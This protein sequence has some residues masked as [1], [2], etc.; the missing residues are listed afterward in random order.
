MTKQ[1]R[2]EDYGVMIGKLQKGIRNKITDVPGVKVGH[3]TLDEGDIKTGVTAIM[4]IPQNIF[5]QKCI[6]AAHVINGY[7]KTI[8][9]VQVEEL[10][11]LES[12]IL[13]TNTLCASRVADALISYTLDRCKKEEVS[14]LSFNPVVG[15]CNDSYLNAIDNRVITQ[16][17]VFKAIENADSDFLEGDVGA[18]KGMS[19]HN[20]K[21]G[22]GSASRLLQLADSAYTLGA[23][24]LANYGALADLT[25]DGEKV[26]Q[27]I[28]EKIANRTEVDKGSI[29]I[30]LATD[31]P[32]SDRQL[33]RV[34][35]RAVVGM[36]RVGSY[37]GHGSGDIVIGFTTHQV[38]EPYKLAH[39]SI[40]FVAQLEE[41]LLE[42]VFRGAAES[43]EEAILNALITANETTGVHNRTRYALKDFWRK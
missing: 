13:L 6:A 20:L 29:I 9:L 35:K 2:I 18:G 11:L 42:T 36:A 37:I 16:E 25:I 17:H 32:L 31:L 22:I 4:P 41:E 24:V 27:T 1:K 14:C 8:G 21:G 28:K 26:G 30:V 33:K 38:T 10:G 19:C 23:L 43:T 3:Y 39:S 15:E 40:K 7:G 5:N 12:P 34:C